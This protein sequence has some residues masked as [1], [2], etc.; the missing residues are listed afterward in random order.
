MRVDS[1][2][3]SWILNSISKKLVEAFSY[4]NNAKELWEELKERFNENNGHLI[5]QTKR[6]INSF[7]QGNMLTVVRGVN[8]SNCS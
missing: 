2:V 6:E 7:C 4:M 8:E 1:I 3:C 5:Y